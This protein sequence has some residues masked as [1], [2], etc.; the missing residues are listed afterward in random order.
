MNVDLGQIGRIDTRPPLF[1]P[2]GAPF[3]DDPWIGQSM[4]AAHLD[5]ERDSASRRHA[6]IDREVAWIV[7]RLSLKPGDA[8]LDV[9]CGPG[10]YCERLAQRG[11]HVVGVDLS[12]VAIDYAQRHTTAV[13]YRRADYCSPGALDGLGSFA[14]AILIYLDVG[15][16]SDEPRARM[17][18]NVRRVIKPGGAFIFDVT[19]PRRTWPADGARTWSA[20]DGGFWRPGPH[21][22]LTRHFDYPE[23]DAHLRQTI[24]LDQRGT[25][26]VYRIWDR[27]YTPATLAPILAAAGLALE[28]VRG[29]LVGTAFDES[30]STTVGIVA[31][32]T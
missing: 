22:E 19:T 24:I 23:A 28:S 11:L 14:A 1:A 32:V 4:L 29:D 7:E 16:L 15:V 27:A 3:W 6:T 17:L 26:S 31:Q 25:A 30:S 10:L 21:L 12:P 20:S 5:P 9:G 8:I 18:A 2:H 13:T